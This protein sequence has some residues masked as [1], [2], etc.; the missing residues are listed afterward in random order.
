MKSAIAPMPMAIIA[1]VM[2]KSHRAVENTNMQPKMMIAAWAGRRP[3]GLRALFSPSV[4][5]TPPIVALTPVLG[6]VRSC[7]RIAR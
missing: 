4:D 5:A 3:S 7:R 1:F 2:T 6:F